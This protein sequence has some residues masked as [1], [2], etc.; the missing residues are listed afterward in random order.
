MANPFDQFDAPAN[1]FNQF[2]P[3]ERTAVQQ[4]ARGVGLTA[5]A[6]TDTVANIL[7]SPGNLISGTINSLRPS[8]PN[9][10]NEPHID[11]ALQRLRGSGGGPPTS[12]QFKSVFDYVGTL[13]GRV[14][15]AISQGSFSPFDESR[16]QRLTPE[17]TTEKAI[18]GTAKGA[19]EAAAMLAGAGLARNLATPGGAVD[20]IA[21]VLLQSPGLQVVSNA[22]GGGVEGV[23]DSPAAGFLTTLGV[24]AAPMLARALVP[25]VSRLTPENARLLAVGQR[26]GIP[27]STGQATQNPSLQT[28]ESVMRNLPL[29][30][31]MARRGDVNQ[32]EQFARAV[33]ERAG[34]TGT[35]ADPATLAAGQQALRGVRQRIIDPATVNLDPTFQ[36]AAQGNTAPYMRMIDPLKRP[37]VED[38]VTS[39][40]GRTTMPGPEYQAARTQLGH[41]VEN[42][43]NTDYNTSRALKSIRNALDEAFERSVSP[44]DAAIIRENNSQYRNLKTI[45]SAMENQQGARAGGAI[46]PGPLLN[47]VKASN[48]GNFATGAGDLN[49]LARFGQVFVRDPVPNSGTPQRLFWQNLLTGGSVLGAGSAAGL[50]V[51]AAASLT[52]PPAAQAILQS[53]GMQNALTG[54][55]SQFD[56]SEAAKLL[57]RV[58][59]DRLPATIEG[60]R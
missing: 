54:A 22:A 4:G 3:R 32:Q 50:P 1:P 29:S 7:G 44:A 8:N 43:R 36:A 45:Q 41:M 38:Y 17:N 58:L 53:K 10:N 47:A 49:D 57:A 6:V 2:D 42:T 34:I 28:A 27:V 51:T 60:K 15:D 24:G 30:G 33:L 12:D 11:R 20:R 55:T 23:T 9:P 46:P 26:E 40:A 48:K 56:T 52:L 31:G 21:R 16:T 35:S 5:Q 19:S 14:S 59:A 25:N 39:L 13:P 18:Y 37:V